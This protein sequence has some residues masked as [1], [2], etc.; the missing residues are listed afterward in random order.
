M[1]TCAE[2]GGRWRQPTTFPII[3]G[4]SAGA[5]NAAALHC[6]ADTL[7]AP[8]AHRPGVA[9]VPCQPG[10]WGRFAERDAQRARWLT[11]VSWAGRWPLAAHAPQIAAGQQAARK[12]IGQDGAAGAPAPAFIR[13][14]T[15]EGAGRHG[16]QLQLGRARHLFESAGARGNR[17]R[18]QRKAARDRIT[19]EHLLASSAIPFIFRPRASRWTTTSNTLA[20]AP[21]ASP[22]P[23]P[24]PSTGG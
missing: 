5:I 15:T 10:V 11:L 14:A 24:R 17:V 19:H 1:P 12:T 7:T 16:V 20:M 13:R 3:T 2:P 8:C 4:T 18:S 23:S 22:R 6:G 21:C 9:A